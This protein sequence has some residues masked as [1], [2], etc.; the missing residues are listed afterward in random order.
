[1]TLPS[2]LKF[3]CTGCGKCCRDPLLPLTNADLLRIVNHSAADPAELVKWVSSREI[4]LPAKDENFVSLRQGPRVMVLRHTR[5]RCLFL[6]TDNRCTIYSFRPLGCRIFPFDPEFSRNGKLLHLR[7]ID[8]T[9][10]LHEL[11]GS[12][13]VRSLLRLNQDTERELAAYHGIV[14]DWNREQKRRQR[15][16]QAPATAAAFLE[17]LGCS[18]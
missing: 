18:G 6:G 13:N 17:H 12:N 11:D 1:M 7:M 16:G 5:G 14:A 4:A 10:C 9:D 3:R 15:R 2:L 8:A